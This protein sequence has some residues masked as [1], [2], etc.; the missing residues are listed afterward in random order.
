ME[1]IKRL[2]IIKE[3]KFVVDTG[4][5]LEVDMFFKDEENVSQYTIGLDNNVYQ[6]Y[7]TLNRYSIE[8]AKQSFDKFMKFIRYSYFNSYF[9]EDRDSECYINYL[10][11]DKWNFGVCF[12]IIYTFPSEKNKFNWKNPE[13]E[14]TYGRTFTD[15]GSHHEVIAI[16]D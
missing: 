5:T 14:T 12:E 10:T 16:D 2:K 8:I 3:T 7:V 4:M 15:H 11:I 13:C 9:I 6:I 1:Q